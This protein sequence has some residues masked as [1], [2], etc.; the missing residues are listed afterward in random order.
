MQ[1]SKQLRVPSLDAFFFAPEEVINALD[2]MEK[3]SSKHPIN[4]LITGR[5]GCGKSSLVRQFASFY[6]RPLAVFQVGLLSEPGQL[7]GQHGLKGGE[8]YY[9]EFLFPKA[10]STPR[11]II[12]LEEINRPEHPK[13]LNELFSVLSEDRCI[14][15]DEL[16]LVEVAPEIV[17]FA[18]MNEGEEYTGTE[19]LDVA[20]RDRFYVINMDY[21]PFAVERKVLV[22]KTG[23]KEEDASTILRIVHKLR[24]DSQV[25]IPVS[26]RHSLMIAELVAMGA[27]LKEAITYS[28]QVSKDVLESVLLSVHIETKDMQVREDSY[29]IFKPDMVGG[30][31]CGQPA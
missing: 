17:F 14:W 8:T 9:Q 7:F 15:V 22:L 16:G 18:T 13:A 23:I 2:R 21:L 12:H 10:I 31:G 11:C 27:S 5:Q 20:L 6:N 29:L 24:G 25:P 26:T 19:A 28:L 4:V 1:Y 30:D 3:L